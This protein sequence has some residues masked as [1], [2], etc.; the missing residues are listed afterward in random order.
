MKMKWTTIWLIAL[1]ILFV[2][3]LALKLSGFGTAEISAEVKVSEPNESE[4]ILFEINPNN[5]PIELWFDPVFKEEPNEPIRELIRLFKEVLD[6]EDRLIS[7]VEVCFD[8]LK[9][10]ENPE[11][12]ENIDANSYEESGNY[13]P[14]PN[15]LTMRESDVVPNEPEGY[16]LD[17]MSLIPTWPEY[18][19]LEKD[20]VII[21]DYD[22]G[23]EEAVGKNDNGFSVKTKPLMQTIQYHFPKGTKIYFKD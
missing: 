4:G 22:T 21:Y 3:A 16:A 23:F 11:S 15:D 13:E 18:I 7:L 19:E 10:L 17:F 9:K 14:E 20:L 5:P 1:T 8:R 2:V 12:N 6:Q